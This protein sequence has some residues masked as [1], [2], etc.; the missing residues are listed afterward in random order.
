[1]LTFKS[2]EQRFYIRCSNFATKFNLFW[3]SIVGFL[4]RGIAATVY[5]ALFDGVLL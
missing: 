3:F 5:L 2:V 1:M 4:S